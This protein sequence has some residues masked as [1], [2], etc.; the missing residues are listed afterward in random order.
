VVVERPQREQA[1]EHQQ[2]VR[3]A[4]QLAQ[5]FFLSSEKR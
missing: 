1:A 5:A 3:D 4:D 2:P